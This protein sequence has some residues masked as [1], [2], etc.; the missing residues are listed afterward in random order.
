VKEI[1]GKL[2]L[3]PN[4]VRQHL[5]VLE[6][7]KLV[8]LKEKKGKL[9][10]PAIVYSLHDNAME[11]FPKVYDEFT[12]SLLEEIEQRF[13]KEE[14]VDILEKIG[15]QIVG[16][17]VKDY[18]LNLDEVVSNEQLK[19]RIDNIVKIYSDFGKFPDLIEEEDSYLLKNYNCLVYSICEKNP[20]VCKVDEKIVEELLGTKSIKEK[21]IRN[22]DGYCLYKV[23][24][25][26]VDKN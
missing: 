19:Q 25:K 6:R 12:L 24:K 3:T 23:S 2:E 1:A 13:G 7:E 22:G 21:C 20:N 11:H 5:G 17:L 10:R 4:G 16:N 26:Q 15:K 18:R 8:V 14:I 9:G